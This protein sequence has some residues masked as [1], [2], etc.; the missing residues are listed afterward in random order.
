MSVKDD[1]RKVE[2]KIG[3]IKQNVEDINSPSMELLRY[4]NNREKMEFKII[5]LLIV[6]LTIMTLLLAGS[7]GYIIY[8][9]NDIETVTTTET[10]NEEKVEMDNNSGIN[11]YIGGDNSGEINNNKE[12]ND[13]KNNI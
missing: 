7:I 9:L 12:K 13:K 5:K 2:G 3:S 8:L 1:L 10:V 4:A 6:L 11:N